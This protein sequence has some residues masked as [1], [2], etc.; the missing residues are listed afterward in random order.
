MVGEQGVND[1]ITGGAGNDLIF[2][3]TGDNE[4]GRR[5]SATTCWSAASDDDSTPID[6]IRRLRGAVDAD[7]MVG[8]RGNDTYVVDDLLDVVVEARERGYRHGPDRTGRA[9]DRAHGQRREPDLHGRRRRPV[10]RHRQRL[11]NVI[12]GGDLADTL[13]GLAGNDR[14]EGGLG[15][16]TL[17]GGTATIRSTAATTSTR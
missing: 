6:D 7:T 4:P 5:R 15:N 2:G 17:N 8:R 14:L 13:S 3:G 12:T 11:N 9:L 16:D 1:V 10:R